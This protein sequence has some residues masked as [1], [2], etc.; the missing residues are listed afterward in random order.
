MNLKQSTITL[1]LVVLPAVT[2]L[3]GCME[4]A[5]PFST[6]VQSPGP[7]SKP[8]PGSLNR[9]RENTAPEPTAVQ[10]AIE[11]SKKY[12]ALSEET[13][14]LKMDKKAVDT[15]NVRLKQQLAA[16]ESELIQT[17]KEL[18]EANDL[19]VEMRIELNNW[20]TDVLGFRD[21]MRRADKAQLE[22][23]LKI[24]KALGGEISDPD[25]ESTVETGI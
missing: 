9:F 6:P 17:K 24:L 19:L 16:S 14:L 5:Q 23:L 11:L 1:L 8:D 7:E 22:T 12:A 18:E 15:E 20:K 4:I 10:S 21:E 25:P 3:T 13:A 2:V